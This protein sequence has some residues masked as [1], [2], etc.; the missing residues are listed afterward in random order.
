[1][2]REKKETD[3]HKEKETDIKSEKEANGQRKTSDR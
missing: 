2:N 1:M 3:R